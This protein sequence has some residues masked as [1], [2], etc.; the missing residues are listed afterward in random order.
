MV[1]ASVN[2]WQGDSPHLAQQIGLGGQRRGHESQDSNKYR[3]HSKPHDYLPVKARL[4]VDEKR[5]KFNFE[6]IIGID[7]FKGRRIPE[8]G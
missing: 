2:V 5:R 4:N 7:R 1:D 8:K 3:H 6:G